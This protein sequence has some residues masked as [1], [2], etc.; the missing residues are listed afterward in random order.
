[1]SQA[2]RELVR[3]EHR[4]GGWREGKMESHGDLNLGS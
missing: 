3:E 1:M 2:R 4:W